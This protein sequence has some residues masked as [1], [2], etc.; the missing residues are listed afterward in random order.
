M[1]RLI[2]LVSSVLSLTARAQADAVE[3]SA[4]PE[5]GERVSTLACRP[6]IACMAEIVPKGFFEVEA[7]YGG[8][9][10]AGA[11]A[12]SGQLLLK[13]SLLDTVQL[14]LATNNLFLVGQGLAPRAVDGVMPGLKVKFNDQGEVM[15]SN[16]ISVHVAFPTHG[17]EGAAQRTIDASAWWYISKDVGPVHGDINFAVNVFDVTHNPTP[18]G[19]MTLALSMPIGFGFGVMSEAYTLF[20]NVEAVPVDGGWLN[21][22][23]YSPIPE[24]AFDAGADVG[25]YW[26]TRT[27]SFFAGITFVPQ[28]ASRAPLT[29][30]A[31]AAQ[32]VARLSERP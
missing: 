13:Y 4:S 5:A 23:S 21:A 11:L 3:Q 6:T 19:L 20:G 12:H 28:G 10:S 31:A 18:Q 2:L 7:G 22:I 1:R 9:A 29:R 25:F 16:G 30:T 27:V 24:I 32:P 8:R 15:P 14:Q 26:Q 17:F